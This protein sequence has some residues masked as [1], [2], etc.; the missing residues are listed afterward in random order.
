MPLVRVRHKGEVI[1]SQLLVVG[2]MIQGAV[3][4]NLTCSDLDGQLT[5]DDIEVFFDSTSRGDQ[6]PFDVFIDV[7]ASNFP[8]RQANF[9]ERVQKLGEEI[10]QIFSGGTKFG[11]WVK[12]VDKP[13]WYD[14]R[15]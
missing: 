2:P 5:K 13:G 8:S 12:L 9:T 10:R 1:S 11:L 7:E 6:T 14:S 15:S 4:R 3:A